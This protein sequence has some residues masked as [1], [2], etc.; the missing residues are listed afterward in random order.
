MN[1]D[2]QPIAELQAGIEAI[3]MLAAAFSP[4]TKNQIFALTDGKKHWSEK[5]QHLIKLAKN[6][7]ITITTDDELKYLIEVHC[8]N[9]DKRIKKQF[10]IDSQTGKRKTHLTPTDI[11]GDFRIITKPVIGVRYHISW[12]FSG[13]V[14]VLKKVEGDICYLDN[15]KHK[16]TQLLKCKVSELRGLR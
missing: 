13:A 16:R 10:F 15:P 8:P 6:F 1:K 9:E 5:K 2:L 3:P 4:L 14:F 7:G 12:A 11:K